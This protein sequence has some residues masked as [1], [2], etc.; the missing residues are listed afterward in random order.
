MHVVCPCCYATMLNGAPHGQ[1]PCPTAIALKEAEIEEKKAHTD[2]L[3]AQ[4][5]ATVSANR[6][7]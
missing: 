3:R 1:D 2:L 4:R 5:D 7:R 6:N